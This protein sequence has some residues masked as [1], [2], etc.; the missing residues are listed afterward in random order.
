MLIVALFVILLG[1]AVLMVL[2]GSA[3]EPY[4]R[5]AGGIFAAVSTAHCRN[6]RSIIAILFGSEGG[7]PP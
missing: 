3:N 5:R 4:R 6:R 1:A 7:G 2:N